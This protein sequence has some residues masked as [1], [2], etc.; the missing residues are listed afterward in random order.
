MNHKT[1]LDLNN[2]EVCK[3]FLDEKHYCNI[4]LP[5]Y[6]TF[7]EILDEI[8]RK[9]KGK[10][11][12]DFCPKKPKDYDDINYK[13]LTNKDGKYAFRPLQLIHPAIY[14]ALVHEITEKDNWDYIKEKFNSFQ[15]NK[16]IECCS[17]PLVLDTNTNKKGNILNWWHTVEQESI[18]LSLHFEYF[19][20]TDITDCYS[21]IYTHSIPWALHTKT[22]AKQER[23][24]NKLLGNHIDDFL[25][26]MSYGQTNGI[27]Q[28]S[29]LMD[30]IAEIVL[31]YADSQLTERIEK[32]KIRNDEY[33]ILRYRDDYRIFVNNPQKAELIVKLLSEVL[34][35]LGMKLNSQ[36]T[37][38]SNNVITDSIKT[39]KLYWIVNKQ[40]DNNLQKHLFI[41]HNLAS[42]YPNSGSLT[43]SLL[44]F[45]KRIEKITNTKEDVEVLISILVDMG[46]RNPKIYPIF[47]A[48]LSKLLALIEDDIKKK[49][50]LDSIMKRT[51]KVPNIGFLSI[52]LQRLTLKITYPQ[53]YSEPICKKIQDRTIPLWNS[54]WLTPSLKKIV[55][56]TSVV[57]DKIIKMMPEIIIKDEVDAFV[58]NDY[59]TQ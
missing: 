17:I 36:K 10:K 23:N 35:E 27:P 6:F 38:L 31:G 46:Y 42:K 7:Q 58:N 45:Y 25:Q 59:S 41:I 56:N 14:V 49:E 2:N 22:I 55:V 3:Y 48:I 28:G 40:G 30:F 37:F 19:I 13:L 15:S 33:K 29:T 34:I 21:S 4:D 20:C 52:W 8:D 12:S 1:I 11:F 47:T 44:S 57:D 43:K 9:I 50:I 26:S 18:K 54:D 24:K 51:E 39:D 53:Q 5:N 32:E 16:N